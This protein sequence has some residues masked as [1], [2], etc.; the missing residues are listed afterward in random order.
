MNRLKV[1]I[2][3][4]REL[5]GPGKKAKAGFF[6]IRCNRETENYIEL[7]TA[8]NIAFDIDY[9]ESISFNNIITKGFANYST[10]ILALP[11]KKLPAHTIKLLGKSSHDH[12]ISIIAGYNQINENTRAFFGIMRIIGKRLHFPPVMVMNKQKTFDLDIDNDIVMID[13]V[14][15]C[16]KGRGFGRYRTGEVKK[17]LVDYLERFF[18]L[19]EKVD[20][21]ADACVIAN[22]K[23]KEDPAII[24][25]HYGKGTNYYVSLHPDY[26]LKRFNAMNRVMRELIRKN[27]GWGMASINLENTMIMRMDDPGTCER[28][29]L[30]GYDTKPMGRDTWQTVIKILKKQRARLS[31]MYIPLWVDDGNKKNGRLLVNG[32]EVNDRKNGYMYNSK[33]IIFIQ[34]QRT[35]E[36][37]IYDYS[38]EYNAIAEGLRSGWLD[39]ESHGLTH[40]DTDLDRWLQA[41]DRYV[42]PDWY[43]EFRHVYDNRDSSEEE[44]A[45]VLLKS[46]EKL[47]DFFGISPSTV[48]PSG[49]EQSH[50]SE[51]VAH[52]KGYKLFSADYHSIV[53]GEM[54]I[55]NNKIRSIFFDQT[56]PDESYIK[57][58]YPV[59]G[60]FHDFDIVRKGVHWLEKTVDKWK[61]KGISK[62]MTLRELAGY[63][64]SS[65]E[66]L[67]DGNR[68]N[69]RVDVSKT[70]GVSDKPESR[71]FSS[72]R[73]S[74]D[75]TL[76]KDQTL[77]FIHVDSN[78]CNDFEYDKAHGQIKLSLPPFRMKDIQEITITL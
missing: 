6:H 57:S 73:M 24:K 36:E 41:E 16:L 26:S 67:Q 78:P 17:Y 19:Y 50:N 43:H 72:H 48:T 60:V 77:A 71:F 53:K 21:A 22:I 51:L 47:E 35:G 64:C 10:I 15:P 7:L 76:P 63:L 75:I 2:L 49:H 59:V 39:I 28:V 31:V 56:N 66:T 42:N 46:A 45:H 25:H 30:K 62:F 8:C 18:L 69:I 5:F 3:T 61:Q 40:V 11:G 54:I 12:G 68:M 58:G 4:S 38:E 44:Q 1:L 55:N 29:Y 52:D 70:G 33:D 13:R 74:I 27:S 20:V 65:I 23:E 37:N 9:A 34:N 32:V 14:K